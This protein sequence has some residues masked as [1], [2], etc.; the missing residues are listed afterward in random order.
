MGAIIE[1]SNIP[2]L[3]QSLFGMSNVFG[4]TKASNKNIADTTNAQARI[5][6]K[7]IRGYR[8]T[9]KN[10]IEKTMP[11]DFDEDCSVGMWLENSDIGLQT[12]DQFDKFYLKY[13]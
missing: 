2:N 6:S 12:R 3:N 11:K 13:K 7:L 10:T 9:I 5:P 4:A 8:L 1:P